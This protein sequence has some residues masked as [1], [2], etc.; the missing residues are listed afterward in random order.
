M[1]AAINGTKFKI[2]KKF[3]IAIRF[4]AGDIVYSVKAISFRMTAEGLGTD[5][6]PT[7]DGAMRGGKSRR[8]SRS[9]SVNTGDT[10]DI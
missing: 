7:L 9:R 4:Q 8:R 10:K 2:I 5:S 3:R 1:V 6:Q